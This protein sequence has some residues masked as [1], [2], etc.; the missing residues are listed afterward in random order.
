[1]LNKDYYAQK[2]IIQ[3]FSLETF[4]N[5]YQMKAVMKSRANLRRIIKIASTG[6]LPAVL[7]SAACG[8]QTT[9]ADPT[10]IYADNNF[11]PRELELIQ[12]GF[13]RWYDATGS[14]RFDVEVVTSPLTD[15]QFDFY[16]H[17]G[18]RSNGDPA[19]V[20]K[21]L[22]TD[23]GFSQIDRGNFAGITFS[24]YNSMGVVTDKLGENWSYSQYFLHTAMHEA[25]HLLGFGYGHLSDDIE[26]V[27]HG[28]GFYPISGPPI[29]INQA[30]LDVYCGK[31]ENKCSDGATQTCFYD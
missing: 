3:M 27:M 4:K 1:L 17:M 31:K 23:P 24:E 30:T 7:A 26:S 11:T 18:S 8:P 19:A 5:D 16:K 9:I 10:H 22:T 25:G 14:P 21:I 15:G 12:E 28:N 20:Y 6:I 2:S 13:D 29:C